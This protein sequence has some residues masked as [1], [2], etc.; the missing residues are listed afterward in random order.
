MSSIEDWSR[1]NIEELRGLS[2]EEKIEKMELINII[3]KNNIELLEMQKTIEEIK[4]Q[5][6]G[7]IRRREEK[8]AREQEETDRWI[9]ECRKRNEKEREEREE[10]KKIDEE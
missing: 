2:D 1:R 9:E 3:M 7:E 10:Q 8:K 5:R 4:R 6:Q